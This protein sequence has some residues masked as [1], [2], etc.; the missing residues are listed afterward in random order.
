MRNARN[1]RNAAARDGA[2]TA[3]T[4]R[5]RELIVN[6]T[7][8]PGAP[9]IERQLA[10]RLNVGRT[11]V[12][13]ALQLLQHEGYVTSAVVG[14]YSRTTVA[15]LTTEDMQ[16]VHEIVG[17]VNGMA[18]R[19]AASL[20]AP[21]RKALA[22]ELEHIND[23]LAQVAHADPTAFVTVHDHDRRFHG[24]CVAAAGNRRLRTLYASLAP[25][26][27]R[28]GRMY[29][30]ALIDRISVSCEEHARII[31]A[32]RAGD[33][34]AAELRTVENFLNAAARLRPVIES[35]GERGS[36]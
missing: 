17:A 28:Y 10:L 15:P 32:I 19:R 3:A 29:A 7:L 36:W 12:R 25:Q 18:A 31:D 9:L 8:G 20:P 2:V 13:S 5:I 21:A 1:T 34:P 11:T 22:D 16:E 23:S 24:R 35:I 14:K 33:P 27:E 30:T 4:D 6:A 26:G